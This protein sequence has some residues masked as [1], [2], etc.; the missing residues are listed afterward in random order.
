MVIHSDRDGRPL[1]D[2]QRGRVIYGEGLIFPIWWDES[3]F[4]RAVSVFQDVTADV[5][6]LVAGVPQD[7]LFTMRAKPR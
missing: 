4:V 2:E 3:T 6:F 1:P 5:D 7:R